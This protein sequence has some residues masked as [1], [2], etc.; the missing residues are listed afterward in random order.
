M[1]RWTDK[2]LPRRWRRRRANARHD[3]RLVFVEFRLAL[4]EAFLRAASKAPR[5]QENGH[6]RFF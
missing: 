2:I 5:L 6:A 1:K 4:T 3:H